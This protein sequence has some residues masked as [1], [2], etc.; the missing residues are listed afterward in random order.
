MRLLRTL[1]LLL[2]PGASSAPVPKMSDL[3][4]T[5][6][7]LATLDD[8]RAITFVL[9]VILF[10]QLVERWIAGWRHSQALDR[11]IA[12]IEKSVAA[13]ATMAASYQTF[14]AVLARLEMHLVR[15]DGEP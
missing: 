6:R 15:R 8:W 11:A 13:D 1:P 7:V 14:A 5:G 10:L 3:N 9:V 12:A 4:D 2:L